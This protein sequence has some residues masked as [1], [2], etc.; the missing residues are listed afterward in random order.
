MAERDVR[1]DARLALA[2]NW[3]IVTV[4]VRAAGVLLGTAGISTTIAPDEHP[5]N[6]LATTAGDYDLIDDAVADARQTLAT[7]LS[8]LAA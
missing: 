1:D 6:A 4:E 8:E 7:L 3:R 2:L 5:Q